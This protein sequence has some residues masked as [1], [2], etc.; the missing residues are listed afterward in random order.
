MQWKLEK[1]FNKKNKKDEKI[2]IEI[3][4]KEIKKNILN[5]NNVKFN[6]KEIEIKDGFN[7][8]KTIRIRG[9]KFKKNTKINK[10]ED[11]KITNLI[12]NKKKI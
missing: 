8:I 6:N 10:E 1:I 4:N 9:Y 12:I 3:K 7:K 2:K 5:I 11:I